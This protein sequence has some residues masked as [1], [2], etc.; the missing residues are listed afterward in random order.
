MS[1]FTSVSTIFSAAK[2][3]VVIPRRKFQ[4]ASFFEYFDGVPFLLLAD[5]SFPLHHLECLD[6]FA[7]RDLQCE[8]KGITVGRNIYIFTTFSAARTRCRILL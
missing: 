7:F 1:S 3:A 5:C 8:V 2:S 6:F 4:F